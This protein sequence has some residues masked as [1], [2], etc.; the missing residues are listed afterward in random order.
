MNKSIMFVVLASLLGCLAYVATIETV[1]HV[2]AQEQTSEKTIVLFLTTPLCNESNVLAEEFPDAYVYCTY[3]LNIA[4]ARLHY[5]GFEQLYHV[6]YVSNSQD[7]KQASNGISPYGL[8]MD[9][10]KYSISISLDKSIRHELEHQYCA[11]FYTSD[12]LH[13]SPTTG[14]KN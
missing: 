14:A 6:V 1:M 13:G 9:N 2:Y 8:T 12:G 4:F 5:S 11:C 7:I 3:E 10:Y